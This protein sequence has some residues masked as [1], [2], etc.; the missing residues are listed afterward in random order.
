MPECDR[1]PFHASRFRSL[2]ERGSLSLS[3]YFFFLASSSIQLKNKKKRSVYIYSRGKSRSRYLVKSWSWDSLARW[4]E[5][6]ING[7]RGISRHPRIIRRGASVS[8]ERIPG[9][10]GLTV[11]SIIPTSIIRMLSLV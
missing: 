10:Y 5:R 11:A 8:I 2:N 7:D 1:K 4:N 9:V 6:E 3:L